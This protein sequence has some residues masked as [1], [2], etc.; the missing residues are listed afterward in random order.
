MQADAP[1]TFSWRTVPSR[2]YPDSTVWTFT[3]EPTAAGTRIEQRFEVRKL[4]PVF[5]RLFYLTTPQHRDRTEALTADMRALGEV[6]L[7]RGQSEA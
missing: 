1:H 2:L 6:A 5:D 3:I 4:N 7:T